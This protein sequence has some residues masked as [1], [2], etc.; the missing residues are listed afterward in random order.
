MRNVRNFLH[1]D[2]DGRQEFVSDCL[3]VLDGGFQPCPH[4]LVGHSLLWSHVIRQLTIEDSTE[5]DG[6]KEES[7]MLIITF[8]VFFVL[9]VCSSHF[10]KKHFL[11]QATFSLIWRNLLV[12]NKISASRVTTNDKIRSGHTI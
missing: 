6:E 5:R 9:L 7:L 2:D 4:L 3:H 11:N 1:R 10:V 8:E 12:S